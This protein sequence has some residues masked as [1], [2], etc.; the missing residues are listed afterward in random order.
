MCRH[1]L[2]SL[3]ILAVTYPLQNPR[4][5]PH[6]EPPVPAELK[7]SGTNGMKIR[8]SRLTR[9]AFSVS[10]PPVSRREKSLTSWHSYLTPL[11]PRSRPAFA[12]ARYKN[13]G[14]WACRYVCVTRKKEDRFNETERAPGFLSGGNCFGPGRVFSYL[15]GTLY[16][17]PRE[18]QIDGV[19]HA[20]TDVLLFWTGAKELYGFVVMS[21]AQSSVLSG[22][23]KI[24][25]PLLAKGP[26]VER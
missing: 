10:K 25:L 13:D 26:S 8:H 3:S 21:K 19:K 16:G 5:H 2:S 6:H 23:L 1:V 18:A 22:V 20:D 11:I 12:I 24:L 7:G 9:T 14:A 15:T 4:Q 17:W